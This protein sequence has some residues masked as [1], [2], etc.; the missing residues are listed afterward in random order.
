MSNKK[1]PRADLLSSLDAMFESAAQFTSSKYTLQAAAE[2]IGNKQQIYQGLK[3]KRKDKK[4]NKGKGNGKDADKPNENDGDKHLKNE[5][6]ADPLYQKMN[7]ELLAI[8]LKDCSLKSQ[9][10]ALQNPRQLRETLQNYLELVTQGTR[11]G[12]SAVGSL[13]NK[14]L[15][16][17][18][19][20]KMTATETTEKAI[21]STS[22]KQTAKLL[23]A[24]RRRQLG[25]HLLSG[26]IKYSDAKQLNDIW[27]RYVSHVIESEL[28]KVEHITD[29]AQL[30]RNTKLQTKLKYLDLSGCPVEV[31][32][33]KRPC[34]VGLCGIIVAE[35]QHT[36]QICCRVPLDD[37]DTSNGSIRTLV[38]SD[39][40]FKVC[41][42]STR[43]LLLD[44]AWLAERG[45]IFDIYFQS[46]VESFIPTTKNYTS[47][48]PAKRVII[49][50]LD[51]CR[52]DK[53]FKVVAGY[54]NH[55][56]LNTDS[57]IN[58]T[59]RHENQIPFLGNVMRHRGSWGV[60]HNHVPTESRPCHVALTAGIYEDPH[61]VYENWKQHP[62]PFDS[63]FNQS[64]SAFLYGNRDVVPMLARHA[65]QAMEEHYTAQEEA[66]M[67]R[68]DTT[69]LDIWAYDKVEKLFTRGTEVKDLELYN[70][71]HQEK[72]VIYC[73]FLG[74]D[75]TGPIYGTDSRKYLENIAVVDTLIEKAYKM[76]E[77]YYGNDGRTAY[78]VTVDHG[79]DLHG[80]HGNNAPAETRTAIIAWGAGVQ[81]PEMTMT[82]N[83]R[84][85]G[86]DIELPTQS[87]EEVLA[88]L[89][90]QVQEEQAATREWG[91][92]L[93]Y[94]RKDVMQVDVAA[95]ISALAGLP[96]PRNS[97][98]II[99]FTYLN[100]DKYRTKAMRAN[101]QQLYNHA[102]RKEEVK[103][104]HRG[105]LF[106]PYSPL[107]QRIPDLKAH[108]DEA[109]SSISEGHNN[110]THDNAHQVV[111]ML[112]QEMI[113]ICR[114][115]IV[116]Y[117]TLPSPRYFSCT[118][119]V[120]SFNWCQVYC[121]G[122]S[123]DVVAI[124]R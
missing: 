29:E 74:T 107:Y 53:L 73:H 26:E 38:K 28:C 102:L 123:S 40:R 65:P 11:A 108:I 22:K 105:L 37:D 7:V 49:F 5:L 24:R 23:S 9:V 117:Q 43:N 114:N 84:K 27:I 1:R 63:V 78:V 16:L 90:S 8:G 67:V 10:H 85:S 19:P 6:R 35:T 21:A 101:A 36:V 93:N 82:N 33:S 98:G 116:Y 71:L 112:S 113:E 92:V 18:N 77:K 17:D 12:L 103:R 95:L 34:N 55:Y 89:E 75:V 120:H 13:K 76:I 122:G 99:P 69:L 14:V 39:S 31:I 44:G 81:G 15:S 96:F 91:T 45:H 64:S 119:V 32:Q 50:T 56:D 52:V 4:R 66:K 124:S 30:A 48:P 87:R 118:A 25:L 121:A 94:K 58:T 104:A 79:M 111:E 88:R 3:R 51:G 41:I 62:V 72:L 109:I 115:A 47:S 20:F 59:F 83:L 2:A 42:S 100:K 46:N 61:A 57:S 106:V 110:A 54:T 80:N 70:Q 97:V 68:K 60:S 86:F